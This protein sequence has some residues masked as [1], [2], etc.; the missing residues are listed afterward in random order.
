MAKSPKLFRSLLFL[1]LLSVLPYATAQNQTTPHPILFA[2]VF[3]ATPKCPP[4]TMISPEGPA[5][6]GSHM[7]AAMIAPSVPIIEPPDS[8]KLLH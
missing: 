8:Q 2:T 6:S 1:G 4:K 3:P 7:V 5:P